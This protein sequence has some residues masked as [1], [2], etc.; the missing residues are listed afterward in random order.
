MGIP[1]K[2]IEPQLI[3]DFVSV[4]KKKKTESAPE[5]PKPTKLKPQPEK[6]Q[7]KPKKPILALIATFFYFV[8]LLSALTVC[9][10]IIW[11]SILPLKYLSVVIAFIIILAAILGYFTFKRPSTKKTKK[12]AKKHTKAKTAEGRESVKV[13]TDRL[14]K[15]ICIFFDLLFT[16]ILGIIYVYLNHTIGFMDSIQASEYQIDNYY[17]L[18]KNTSSYDNLNDL[19]GHTMAVYD[20]GSDNYEKALKEIKEKASL[21][22]T[23]YGSVMNA[24]NAIINDLSDS[25]LIK[26]SLVE[27]LSEVMSTF[28]ID[29]FKILET[30]EFKTEITSTADEN[31]NISEDSFNIFISGIDTYGDISTVARSDVNMIVTVNPRTHTVLLTSIPRDF[32]VQLHGTTGL[33]DKLT[34]AGLYGINMSINTIQDLFNIKIDYFIRVNFDSTIYLINALGG[35]DITPD[36]TFSRWINGHYCYYKEGVTNHLDGLCALRYA[37][38]RKAYGAGDLHRIQNQQEVL[39]AIIDKL[40][41]SK[42]LLARYT[43]ILSSLSGTLETNIPSSQ[44]YK[45]VNNQLD[46]MPSWKIERIA[47]TGTHIDAPTYTFGSQLLYVFVPDMDSVTKAAKKIEAVMSAN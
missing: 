18:V 40:T 9:G 26:S 13:K 30:I 5:L 6:I 21:T 11:L 2:Q 43:D 39:V 32:Y 35:I 20:D 27:A 14:T 41:S 34:H 10:T 24:T 38:E 44:I 15:I 22:T 1:I 42:V 7:I 37:R 25:L 4:K 46:T 29:N 33:K 17:V 16:A 19:D 12:K 36:F 3:S 31:L 23:D 28:S 8:F 47:T 45:L